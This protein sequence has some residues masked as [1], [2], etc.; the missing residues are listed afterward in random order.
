MRVTMELD[1]D[2][3]PTPEEEKRRWI[4]AT[5]SALGIPYVHG[6]AVEVLRNGD[7]I[8]PSMLEAIAS[9]EHTVEFLTFVYWSGGIAERFARALADAARRGVRVSVI[10]DAFGAQAISSEALALLEASPVELRWFRKIRPWRLRRSAHRTHRKVLVVDRRIGF[11]GGVGIA[12]EWCGDARRP[13]EWRETH[14]RVEGPAVLGLWS[15]FAGN[16]FEIEASIPEA[17]APTEELAPAGEASIQ[18]VRSTA[19]FGLSDVAMV[20]HGL[21]SRATRR[22]HITTP[23]FVPDP[24]F[25][26]LLRERIEVGVAVEILVPGPHIDSDLVR[27]ART[28]LLEELLQ[29]GATIWYFQPTMLHAK[30]MTIDGQVACIGSANLN[31]RSLRQDDELLLTVVDQALAQRLDDDFRADLDRAERMSLDRA[32]RRPRWRRTLEKLVAPLRRHL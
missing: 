11:T 10:L 30:I 16:W 5:E 25:V 4:A 22:I 12:D 31:G 20:F 32:R 9:A 21:I 27:L 13:D 8:F 17:G 23:Y 14:F 29:A 3:S 6:N 2:E 1:H 24:A 28:G 19:S 18:V 15:A 26:R 7:A